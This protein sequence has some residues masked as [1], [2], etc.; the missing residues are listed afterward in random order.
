[1]KADYS[2]SFVSPRVALKFWSML[3]DFTTKM[4]KFPSV[5]N[6][7]NFRNIFLFFSINVKYCKA[8]DSKLDVCLSVHLCI[9]IEKKN[10]QDVTE[11]FIALLICSKCYGQFYA[12]HQELETICVLLP[13]MVCSAWLLVV[14][15]QVQSS[16]LCVWV[17]RYCMTCRAT[18]LSLD[19]HPVALHLT[20]H[21][22]QP[23]TVHHRQ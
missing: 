3:C 7:L 20:P 4:E 1:M 9:C 16:R 17:E 21:N 10:Q 5:I 6:N 12:H 2:D 23:S 18:S 14:G 22:Q 19:A 8:E 13:P 15:G 11:W